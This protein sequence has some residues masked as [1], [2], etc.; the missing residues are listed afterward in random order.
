MSKLPDALARQLGVLPPL[1]GEQA[2]KPTLML[3]WALRYA[4]QGLHVFPTTDYIGGTKDGT[5]VEQWY[6]HATIDE[7]KITNWWSQHPEAD[8]AVVPCKSGH[9]VILAVGGDGEDSYAAL[10]EKYPDLDPV[11]VFESR[12]S[13]QYWFD[14]YAISS[15]DFLGPKLHVIGPGRFLFLP[16]SSSK[17]SV[18]YVNE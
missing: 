10:E 3:D 15:A 6:Q 16:P 12:E 18:E 11:F 5:I 7:A 2:P 13:T 1:P 14:G 8:I 4:A 17:I 9:F